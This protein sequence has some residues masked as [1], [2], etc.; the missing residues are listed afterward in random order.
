[1]KRVIIVVVV[2]AGVCATIFFGSEK[3]AVETITYEYGTAIVD[4]P[5]SPTLHMLNGGYIKDL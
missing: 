5:V 2:L 3:T 4:M 1:M